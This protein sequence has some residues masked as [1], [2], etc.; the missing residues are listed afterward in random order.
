MQRLACHCWLGALIAKD[1]P[2]YSVVVGSPGKV[3]ST[4]EIDKEFL[5]EFD[6]TDTCY[7]SSVLERIIGGS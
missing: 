6:F 2:D 4:V 7:D 3:G 5:S 1:I